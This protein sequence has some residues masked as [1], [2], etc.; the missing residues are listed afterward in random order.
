MKKQARILAATFAIFL[1]NATL[2]VAQPGGAAA[3]A[4]KKAEQLMSAKKFGDAI[5][6]I[7]LMI[8]AEPRNIK[9]YMDK[10]ICE[11]K[12]KK[13]E[14]ATASFKKALEINPKHADAYVHMG[15]MAVKQKKYDDAATEFQKAIDLEVAGGK[16]AQY[17]M[18]IVDAMVQKGDLTKAKTYLADLQKT[19]PTNMKVLYYSGEIKMKEKNWAGAKEEYTKIVNNPKFAKMKPA[20][21]ASYYYSLG[22]CCLES[23]DELGAKKYWKRANTGKYSDMIAAKKPDW[24]VEFS[25]A[26]LAGEDPFAP[27]KPAQGTANP[28]KPV[29]LDEFGNPIPEGATTPTE[30]TP[31][32]NSNSGSSSGDDLDWGF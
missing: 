28:A 19:A 6:Y 26:K 4:D 18:M 24:L 27:E 30:P 1:A 13:Y 16:K 3:N 29:R 14:D 22:L 2:V 11:E 25:E 31:D 5:P 20:Q 23:G 10:G 9:W 21:Q 15:T 8:K 7:N 32:T 17:K 12:T